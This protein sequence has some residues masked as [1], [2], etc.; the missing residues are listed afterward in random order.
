M[1]T[2]KDLKKYEKSNTLKGF[3]EECQQH[4]QQL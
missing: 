2:K 4:L 3:N 1:K